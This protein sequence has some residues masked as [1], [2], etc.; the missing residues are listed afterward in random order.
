MVRAVTI[1]SFLSGS[2]R[3]F[4]HRCSNI[5]AFILRHHTG[6]YN[7]KNPQDWMTERLI[8]I[9]KRRNGNGN[10]GTDEDEGGSEYPRKSRKVRNDDK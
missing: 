5:C 2:H 6:P 9:R 7:L 3:L 1:N 8:A 4:M 10:V